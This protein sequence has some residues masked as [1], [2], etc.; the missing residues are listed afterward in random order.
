MKIS[1]LDVVILKDGRTATILDSFDGGNSFYIEASD[2]DDGYVRET[3]SSSEI[4]KILW[5]ADSTSSD[6]S[7]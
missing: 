5:S 6:N 2:A 1:E 3:I 4:E 7:V